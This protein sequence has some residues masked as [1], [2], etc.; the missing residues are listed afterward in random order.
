MLLMSP[1]SSSSGW[2]TPTTGEFS[3][4]ITPRLMVKQSFCTPVAEHMSTPGLWA[5][6]GGQGGSEEGWHVEG[7][8]GRNLHV[9]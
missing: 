1:F 8:S 4:S 6:T 7:A 5:G 3:G 2:T 9:P